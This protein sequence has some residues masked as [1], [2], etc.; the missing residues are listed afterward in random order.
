MYILEHP[1]LKNKISKLS[2]SITDFAI[3]HNIIKHLFMFLN[4]NLNFKFKF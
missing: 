3:V 1:D 4:F 2:M